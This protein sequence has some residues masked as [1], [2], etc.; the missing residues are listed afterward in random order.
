MRIVGNT[1]IAVVDSRE[2][3]DEDEE[4]IYSKPDLEDG[5]SDEKKS[6]S[7]E[8]GKDPIRV[9]LKEMGMVPLLSR[10]GEVEIAKRIEKGKNAVRKALSRSP[11]VVS[12]LLGFGEKLRMGELGV[13]KLVHLT[14]VELTERVLERRRQEVLKQIDEIIELEDQTSQIR[15]KLRRAKKNSPNDKRLF[16]K[17]VRHRLLVAF[18]IPRSSTETAHTRAPDRYNSGGHEGAFQKTAGN[19]EVSQASKVPTPT[20]R[21]QEGQVEAEEN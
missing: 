15:V 4:K 16:S 18:R 14:D 17:L 9:Y 10:A 6:E 3:S 7:Q 19:Q 11:V 13:R 20:G 12:E 5:D 8:K 1:G 21:I 2:R